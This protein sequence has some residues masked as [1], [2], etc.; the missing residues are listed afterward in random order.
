[1]HLPL[2]KYNRCFVPPWIFLPLSQKDFAKY[3]TDVY[4]VKFLPYHS[5]KLSKKMKVLKSSVGYL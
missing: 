2:E 4:L 3:V 5:L 1:M